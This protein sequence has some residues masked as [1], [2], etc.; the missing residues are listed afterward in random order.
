[1]TT[2][3]HTAW[4]DGTTQFKADD[5]NDP[6]SDLDSALGDFSGNAGRI[7]RVNSGE[8]SL[9]FIEPTYDIGGSYNGSPTASLVI[10][11]FPF[12]RSASFPTN[13]SGS[14]FIAGTA[15]TG[16]TQFSL[17]KDGTQ[18]GT[19]TFAAS[20]TVA[21][22]SVTETAFGYGNVFT[23]VAPGSPDATLADLGWCFALD[24]NVYVMATTTTTTTTSSTTTTT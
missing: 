8:T 3:H 14:R 1:M 22:F 4:V 19:A 7:A 18:F 12:V 6:L 13:L 16:S 23:L 20:G 11:R 24:K 21:T 9:E 10:M 5:M 2:N 17:Q 15:A